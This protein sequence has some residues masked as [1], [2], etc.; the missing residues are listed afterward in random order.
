MTVVNGGAAVALTGA[1]FG[2]AVNT[3]VNG[4]GAYPGPGA[5]NTVSVGLFTWGGETFLIA[6]EGSVN[7]DN[8]GA[9]ASADL[10]IRVTGVAGTLDANDTA[11]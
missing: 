11:F 5:A 2:A 8:F 7:N 10:I 9:V 3:V 1:N 6:S 4:G